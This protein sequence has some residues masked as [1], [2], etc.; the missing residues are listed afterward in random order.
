[1]MQEEEL[2]PGNQG[3]GA[4]LDEFSD[5][6]DLFTNATLLTKRSEGSVVG[7]KEDEGF[8]DRQGHMTIKELDGGGE[9][10]IS[11]TREHS[12]P[13]GEASVPEE[14]ASQKS[15]GR[16]AP[17]SRKSSNW[18]WGNIVTAAKK[19]ADSASL[20]ANEAL[21][22]QFVENAKVSANNAFTSV[23]DSDIIKTAKVNASKVANKTIE[24][25]DEIVDH[26]EEATLETERKMP[27]CLCV[28]V[29]GADEKTLNIVRRA[30]R[31]V[32]P[33]GHKLNITPLTSNS[34][35]ASLPVGHGVALKGAEG[36]V[37]NCLD[38]VNK[39]LPYTIFIGILPFCANINGRWY[40]QSAI[41]LHDFS[42]GI[43]LTSF[44]QSF[45]VPSKYLK[46]IADSTAEDYEHRTT[47]F[48]TTLDK[49][50]EKMNPELN[51]GDWR[52]ALTNG[53]ISTADMVFPALKTI[54]GQ[55][56][57]Y[58]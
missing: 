27:P 40:E 49:Q 45:C 29:P 57:S 32:F 12:Q 39:D 54:A 35:V 52:F 5:S 28:I 17:A 50:I 46:L 7:A 2:V 37:Q 25:V 8:G 58:I 4:M 16:P 56:S 1:M 41:V 44:T 23:K 51:G 22:S 55:Y 14:S 15:G 3:V 31:N 30:F 34:G 24:S 10:K 11:P 42:K 9:Q 21:K 48:S 20:L 13:V 43:K 38:R 33:I 47:G 53:V 6:E 26:F 18:D 19:A 36:L